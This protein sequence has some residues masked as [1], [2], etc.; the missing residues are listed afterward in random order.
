MALA[1]R[2]GKWASIVETAFTLVY[3]IGVILLMMNLFSRYSAAQVA[4]RQWI[5]IQ[6]YAQH[7]ADD[8]WSMVISIVVQVDVFLTGIAILVIFLCLHEITHPEL[9][10]LTR[11]GCSFAIV[12]TVTSCIIYYV[13]IASIHQTIMSGGDLAGLGQF[14]ESNFTSPGMAMMQLAWTIFYGLSTLVLAPVFRNHGIEK[15]IRWAFVTNGVIGILVGTLYL[16]GIIW[17]LPLSMAALIVIAF[18]Y[19]LL[20]IYFDRAHRRVLANADPRP[21]EMHLLTN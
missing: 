6:D 18:A 8:Y 13:Q 1:A 16:F 11:I 4:A 7:Y 9:R 3:L 2:I 15:W 12:L 20:A 21:A 17:A 19:P 5:N 14:V 10:I